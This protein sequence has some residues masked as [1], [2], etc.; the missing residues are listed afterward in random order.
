MRLCD[1]NKG[2]EAQLDR[3]DAGLPTVRRL[4]ELGFIKGQKIVCTDI[5]IAGS[6]IAYI[7]CG[8]KLA[9]RRSDCER[10]WVTV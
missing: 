6:P 8:T 3:I 5:G 7:I 4:T 1:L 9:L 10:I 2:Q